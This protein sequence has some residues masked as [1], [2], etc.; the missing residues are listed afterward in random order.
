M[1]VNIL[2]SDDLAILKPVEQWWFS[3]GDT[4][5]WVTANG[6]PVAIKKLLLYPGW[7]QSWMIAENMQANNSTLVRILVKPNVRPQSR[8]DF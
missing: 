6:C 7:S 5:L 8:V 3:K 2:L 4:S 1:P